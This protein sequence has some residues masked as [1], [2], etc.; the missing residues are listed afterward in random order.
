MGN[1]KAVI[2]LGHEF[3]GAVKA[4]QLPTADLDG[5]AP[6]LAAAL[7]S[8]KA[9]LGQ[10]RLSGLSD[11]RASDREA[12]TTNVKR[13]VDLLMKDPVCADK[14]KKKKL[15]VVGAFYEMSSGIVDFLK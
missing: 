6:E 10:D 8:I 15:A 9:G 1:V 7:K 2:V 4:A 13:Q 12:V 5:E 3:C 11:A 14:V